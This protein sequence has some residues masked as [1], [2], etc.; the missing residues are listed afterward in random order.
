VPTRQL[1]GPR[2]PFGFSACKGKGKAEG[3][4]GD[5]KSSSAKSQKGSNTPSTKGKGG[6]CKSGKGK[7]W[8]CKGYG[9]YETRREFEEEDYDY[10]DF[11]LLATIDLSEEE[12]IPWTTVVREGT[13]KNVSFADLTTG[14]SEILSVTRNREG[15]TLIEAAVDS[16]AMDNVMPITMLPAVA[17][18]ESPGSKR[19]ASFRVAN[20]AKIPNLGQ[21][22][23]KFQTQKGQDRQIIFQVASVTRALISV[24]KIKQ[25]GRDVILDAKPRI[26]N[27]KTGEVTRLVEKGGLHVLE[28]WV[29]KV[30]KVV[31]RTVS[32]Q[33]TD[34][35]PLEGPAA[36]G[37]EA[38]E[39]E[40]REMGSD[41]A[42]A[43]EEELVN[44][45]GTLESVSACSRSG[46]SWPWSIQWRS[47]WRRTFTKERRSIASVH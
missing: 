16:G 13:L 34:L 40:D 44:P 46:R 8:T 32:P 24:G 45:E 35:G 33:H 36:P 19:R 39:L 25:A 38:R 43:D 41:V 17:L 30:T 15:W 11:S 47:I 7:T 42:R 20:G 5:S 29:K 6:K 2:V 3:K 18:H 23:V 9:Q 37:D 21:K 14:D 1:D 12:D 22:V 27:H 26:V 31:R 10:S 28:M 4:K